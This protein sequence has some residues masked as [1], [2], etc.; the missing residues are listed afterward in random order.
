MELRSDVKRAEWESLRNNG[1]KKAVAGDYQSAWKSYRSALRLA[2]TNGLQQEMVRSQ[3][4]VAVVVIQLG[5]MDE[6]SGILASVLAT[7]GLSSA[8]LRR[9]NELLS[10][11]F[12]FDGDWPEA[13][14]YW[15]KARQFIKSDNT[16]RR[17]WWH[18]EQC[19]LLI[20]AS[21]LT[22]AEA[23]LRHAERLAA[24]NNEN[25]AW[26]TNL[27]SLRRA[28]LCRAKGE[29]STALSLAKRA[30]NQLNKL[31]VPRTVGEA[32][33]IY[34]ELLLENGQFE[35]VIE[36]IGGQETPSLGQRSKVRLLRL[37][38]E[39]LRELGQWERASAQ[40]DELIQMERERE[41][42]ANSVYLLQE[43]IETSNEIRIQNQK[44]AE[45]NRVLSEANEDRA[46]LMDLIRRDLQTQLVATSESWRELQAI[47]DPKERARIFLA[48]TKSVDH[49]AATAAQVVEMRL[50]EARALN[51]T[52]AYVGLRSL[53]VQAS[54]SVSGHRLIVNSVSPSFEISTDVD[55]FVSAVRHLIVA[56]SADI[57]TS[58]E[59]KVEHRSIA[60]S[61]ETTTDGP[62]LHMRFVGPNLDY[63]SETDLR[64]ERDLGFTHESKPAS[65]DQS[66][67]NLYLGQKLLGYL[68]FDITIGRD[69]S[70]AITIQA[71]GSPSVVAATVS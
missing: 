31:D 43:E 57:E 15:S 9:V 40:L 27:C 71:S 18:Q 1:L 25:R 65:F 4:E 19:S 62:Q 54:N 61:A 16:V 47:E 30:L 11:L 70:G 66:F 45:A 48:A 20:K 42:N 46:Q 7:P 39:A 22:E 60:F 49:L 21:R 34:A 67:I 44:M 32:T 37:H 26:L 69:D 12:Q 36:L 23:E 5:L 33:L 59:S 14:I 35:E 55:H 2:E 64:L 41:T 6:A 58:D 28:E 63:L 13:L 24:S 10:E 53:L 3:I 68:G 51:L 56:F 52:W 17:L 50:V 38:F 8:E 29:S